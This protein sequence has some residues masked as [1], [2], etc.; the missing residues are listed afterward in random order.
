MEKTDQEPVLEQLTRTWNWLEHTLRRSDD[1][2][3]K[4][5]LQWTPQGHG[6]RTIQRLH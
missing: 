5:T 4:Q 2:I 1:G 6:G 3:A